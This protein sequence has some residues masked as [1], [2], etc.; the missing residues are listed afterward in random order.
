M[1]DRHEE[2]V[3]Q[4][5]EELKITGGFGNTPKEKKKSYA[6]ELER[7]EEL[8]ARP[9]R[10]LVNDSTVEALADMERQAHRGLLVDRDELA[11]LISSL[12][13]YSQG[14]DRPFYL[15]A[16]QW[17]SYLVQRVKKGANI[18]ENHSFSIAGGIQPDRLH[19]LLTQSGDDDGFMARLLVFW[20]DVVRPTRISDGCSHHDMTR[21]LGRLRDIRTPYEIHTFEMSADAFAAFDDWYVNSYG[22]RLG[23][24][25]KIGSAYGKLSGQAARLAGLL[26]LLDWAF[27]DEE[28]ELSELL[29]EGYIA[30]ALLLVEVYFV[31][32][33]ERTYHGADLSSEEA[34]I[35]AIL[36]RYRDRK[37][38]E[39]NLRDAR[40][41]WGIPGAR[42]RDAT[43]RFEE[44]AK[45]GE[46]AGW[47]RR[48]TTAGGA[49]DFEVNP[50]LH[51]LEKP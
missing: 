22:K 27:G 8:K 28:A 6:R 32:Q 48:V 2:Q 21:A 24:L 49:K 46:K 31:P 5:I 23:T 17:G 16:W 39:F 15:E 36:Q 42:G 4:M 12:E 33:I 47:I 37:L 35:A 29:E 38:H 14:V 9:P 19:S 10:C 50:L 25:G 11:G 18:I 30:A 43:K 44:A 7:L 13:R 51:D 26:K 40:R 3:D 1:I 41:T 20:P 34:V 45:A